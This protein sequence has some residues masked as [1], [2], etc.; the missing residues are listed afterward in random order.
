MD[1]R[2]SKKITLKTIHR[3][4]DA[5]NHKESYAERLMRWIVN[6]PLKIQDQIKPYK[7][8]ITLYSKSKSN[9]DVVVGY[10]LI[11]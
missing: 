11:K 9:K 6:N 10:R 1:L 2:Y 4:A 5:L 3:I 8:V 7:S